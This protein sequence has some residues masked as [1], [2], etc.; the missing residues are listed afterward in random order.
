MPI[1][2]EK[3]YRGGFYNNK[4]VN[5][6]NDRVYTA[7]DIRKPY[8]V[9]YTDGIKPNEDGTAGDNLKV[10]N[11][12]GF[13]IE[14]LKGFAKIGGAWFENNSN[15]QIVLD[16]PI[17]TTSYDCVILRNDD[18]DNVRDCSIYVKRLS[19]KPTINDL[20]RS[21]GI[22]ELCIAYIEVK[23]NAVAINDVDIIDTRVEGE[24]CNVMSGVGAVVTRTYR[25][26]YFSESLNQKQI[27]IGIP[28]YDR[29]RDSISVI[30]EGRINKN[31]K[32]TNNS[33]VELTIGLPV[34]GTR[35][36]FEVVKNVNA[37]GAESVVQE[38]GQL[39][40]EV[41]LNNNK[42]EYYYY[43]NGVNDNELISYI[44]TNFL[45]SG[46]DDS[47]R[48][49]NIIGHFGYTRAMTGTGTASNPYNLFDFILDEDVNG[50]FTRKVTL[51]FTSCDGIDFTPTDN[52]SNVIF[53][54]QAIR[55]IGANV[56][57]SNNTTGTI[58]RVFNS[59]QFPIAC[60]NC[61][62]WITGYQDCIISRNGTFIN[63]R[64]S[65]TNT[66]N[67]SYC[68]N[69]TTNGVLNLIGGEYYSYVVDFMSVSGIIGQSGTNSVSIL[70]GVSAPTKARTNLFQTHAIY[71]MTGAGYV[72]CYGL[73]TKLTNQL[74]SAKSHIA[75]TIP[76]DKENLI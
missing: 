23:P 48:K 13:T 33:Y 67:N 72:S 41:T 15:Y 50:N 39:R 12:G 68:F 24:L 31:Y 17:S 63:C 4:V 47:S 5:G 22:Y 29:T 56:R 14:I 61:R 10:V 42:L 21:G 2:G 73:I 54:S 43:C 19:S 7:E 18:T 62:F 57:A 16:N 1:Y 46:T 65:I 70:N 35:V 55:I 52:T 53:K 75:G 20:V 66:M 64:G 58:I 11:I 60:E 59:S 51:D 26:T 71:Q 38:V 8:D 28:Q 32:I 49:F 6:N 36:D 27:P 69:V 25:S 34:V 9:I 44:V 30:I 37:A 76:L 45:K 74:D 40:N 3:T